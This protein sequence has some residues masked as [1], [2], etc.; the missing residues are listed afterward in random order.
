MA[1]PFQLSRL[2][3]WLAA[4]VAAALAG[5]KTASAETTSSENAP[6]DS[7]LSHLEGGYRN[8]AFHAGHLADLIGMSAPAKLWFQQWMV[9]QSFSESKGNTKAANR[10]QSESR[11]SR[12]M[13]EARNNNAKLAA[14]V[15]SFPDEEWWFPG[16]SGYFGLMPTVLVNVV[17]GKNARGIGLGPRWTFDP[18][19]STV[20][21]YAYLI[22]LLRRAEWARSSQDG[23][24]LKAGG[25]AGSLMDDPHKD[26]YK[27]SMRNLNRAVNHLRLPADFGTQKVPAGVFSSAVNLL[28]LYKAGR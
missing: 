22:R 27:S 17:A 12:K 11:A 28:E 15:G 4:L 26:R 9:V 2:I 19:A 5:A 20:G 23:Y 13:Y 7:A 14:A 10:T 16:S 18:W 6:V 25:A 21:Y 24:A 1:G 3:P 8:V